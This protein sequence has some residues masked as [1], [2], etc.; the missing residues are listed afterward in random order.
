MTITNIILINTYLVITLICVLASRIKNKHKHL[1]GYG[2]PVIIIAISNFLMLHPKECEDFDCLEN[3]N[4]YILESSILFL[5]IT[6]IINWTL[7]YFLQKK[8]INIVKSY[9]LSLV[10]GGIISI[11][12]YINIISK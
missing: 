7:N 5:A 11:F 4:P 1:F 3:I 12:I 6:F 2:I 10:L 9:I 8:E